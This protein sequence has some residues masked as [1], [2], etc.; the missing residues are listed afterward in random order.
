MTKTLKVLVLAAA[1]SALT[2]PFAL[3]LDE[4]VVKITVPFDFVI[5]DR[6]LPSGEYR[7]VQSE[8]PGVVQIY[9]KNHEHVMTTF[10][11]PLPWEATGKGKLVFRNH[12]GQHFLKMIRTEDGSGVVFPET[13]TEG[14]AQARVKPRP[15]DVAVSA[16][17]TP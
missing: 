3:A 1:V 7:F 8:N 17:V 16:V 5:G 9:S 2:A 14:T 6:Q 13:R 15:G 12:D 4:A 10:C 11:L